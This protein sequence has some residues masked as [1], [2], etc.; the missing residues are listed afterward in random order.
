M[1][2]ENTTGV[3]V[4]L[5]PDSVIGPNAPLVYNGQAIGWMDFQIGPI[6]LWMIAILGTFLLLF[7]CI[8]V[9][10][11]RAQKLTPVSGFRNP[12]TH[13]ATGSYIVAWLMNSDTTFTA[14]PATNS[15]GTIHFQDHRPEDRSH[16]LHSNPSAVISVGGTMGVICSTDYGNVRDLPAESAWSYSVDSWNRAKAA[17]PSEQIADFLDWKNF[18]REMLLKTY[19]Y[20]L[21]VPTYRLLDPAE[22]AVM[23]PRGHKPAFFGQTLWR[24]AQNMLDDASP[25]EGFFEKYMSLIVAMTIGIVAIIGAAAFG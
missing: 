7:A 5:I 20:G 18:G 23:I 1:V 12:G 22:A 2:I 10:L 8:I 17:I 16:W 11:L 25:Q 13:V 9:F 6:P 3:E 4:V 19:P 15:A 24:K 21:V 14:V